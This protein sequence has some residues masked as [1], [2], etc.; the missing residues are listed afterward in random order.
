M[1]YPLTYEQLRT[2]VE[3]SN[4]HAANHAR[5]L[6]AADGRAVLE[7]DVLPHHLNPQGLVHGGVIAGLL[8]SVCGISLRTI[9]AADVGHVTVQLSVS[10][11]RP[12]RSGTLRGI[13]TV[14][15]NGRRIGH[16]TAEV[17]DADGN[18]C[19]AGTGVFANVP[20]EG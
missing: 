14:V 7:I 11:M 6:E 9:K 13:G 8:D 16:A 12:V 19:A 17:V 3:S 20:Q 1:N 4:Y 5:L 10:Y 18:L 2:R 15:R